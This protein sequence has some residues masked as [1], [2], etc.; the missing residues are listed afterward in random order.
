MCQHHDPKVRAARAAGRIYAADHDRHPCLEVLMQRYGWC[1]DPAL[2]F[3]EECR[4]EMRR[5]GRT[6]TSRCTCRDVGPFRNRVERYSLQSA[7][8]EKI[9]GA[10]NNSYYSYT[11]IQCLN[12]SC[13]IIDIRAD[14]HW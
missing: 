7:P 4:S 10:V 8:I 11:C 1:L 13:S 12:W 3:I 5:L 2:N 14:I 9:G 6:P